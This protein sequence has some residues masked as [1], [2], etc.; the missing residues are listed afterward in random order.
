MSSLVQNILMI[1]KITMIVVLI[2]ALF[3]P[4]KY[5]HETA[6]Q[7]TNSS[8]TATDWIKSLGI[9]LI[10]VSFTY[11]GYQ[12]TINFG[13]EVKNPAKNIP[14]GI[15]FGIAT[16]IVLY[17]L[18]NLSYYNVV[19]FNQMKN[20]KEIAYVVV[21]KM[22]GQTGATIF[23]AFLF[24]G[25]L[26]YVNGLLM[27]N[28]RVMFAMGEDGSLPKLF[29]NQH[30]K[31]GVLSFS[32]TVFTIMCMIIL[33]FSQQFERILTFS[34]FL[35]CF[36]MI[37]SGATIF[38][39]RKKTKHLDNTGI[40]KMKLFPLAPIIFIASYV[41]VGGSII[42]N[43][44]QNNYAAAIGVSVLALFIV[45]YFLLHKKNKNHVE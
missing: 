26:A 19:G 1:I 35:D 41:F 27:S 6:V 42:V 33:F 7:I 23:S 11:G 32:L 3:F 30:K 40:Y 34:I 5:A 45:I 15:F 29:A 38:W 21:D 24:F 43:Y 31:T 8:T 10:A 25:V 17:L 2:F 39:F 28:P 20:E 13:N 37:L 12:Q 44:K 9:S 16:I 22:F 18:V 36:G 4:D 14:K